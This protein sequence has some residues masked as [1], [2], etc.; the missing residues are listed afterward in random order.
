MDGPASIVTA[1]TLRRTPR[2]RAFR[3]LLHSACCLAVLVTNT[4]QFRGQE[5]RDVPAT[6]VSPGALEEAPLDPARRS[7][8]QAAIKSRDYARAETLLLEDIRRNPKSP[9]LLT[10]AGGK[11]GR[12]HV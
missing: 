1:L 8:L 7:S 6:G 4:A 10:L 5:I 2:W 12:A 11:I 9:Q 3:A